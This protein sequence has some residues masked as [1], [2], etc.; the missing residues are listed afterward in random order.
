MLY[1]ANFCFASLLKVQPCL[2]GSGATLCSSLGCEEIGSGVA[3]KA[4]IQLFGVV[5]AS[6]CAAQLKMVHQL[7]NN[8]VQM[9]STF[10]GLS[11]SHCSE[12]RYELIIFESYAIPSLFNPLPKPIALLATLFYFPL[13][14]GRFLSV[15]FLYILSLRRSFC[16]VSNIVLG[17]C[18]VFITDHCWF[19]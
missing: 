17:N 13:S 3:R 4:V 6:N 11:L 10:S 8:I 16:F 18:Y 2:V 19:L 14:I 12:L 1:E 9:V 7:L 15:L 5:R